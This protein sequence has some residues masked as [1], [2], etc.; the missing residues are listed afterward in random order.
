MPAMPM[1]DSIRKTLNVVIVYFGLS[2]FGLLG[3]NVS[4]ADWITSIRK[5]LSVRKT[6]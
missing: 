5:L 3:R 2:A 4:N 6:R 1:E